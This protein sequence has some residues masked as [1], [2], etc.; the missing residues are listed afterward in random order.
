MQSL[1]KPIILFD[2][3]Y[4][5]FKTA[6]FKETSFKN[7]SLY[8]EVPE[9]LVKL[10]KENILGIFSEGDKNLQKTK[11]IKTKIYHLFQKEHIY[12]ELKKEKIIE[13][14]K[15]KY[16]NTNLYIVD[17]KL[18]VLSLLKKQ[19]PDM[20]TVW[21]K[22]GPYATNQESIPEF[23]PEAVIENLFGLFSLKI[24]TNLGVC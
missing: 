6:L 16:K 15:H 23:T 17:D 4:T 7:Y 11:L 8:D 1:N 22:R 21:I 24:D 14:I 20:F 2:I 19:N 13:E 18:P 5:L 10:S 9:A 3:D 12:I